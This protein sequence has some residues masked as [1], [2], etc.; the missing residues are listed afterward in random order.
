MFANAYRLLTVFLLGLLLPQPGWAESKLYIVLS[1]PGGAYE[2]VVEGFRQTFSGRPFLH[3]S[4]DETT[5]ARI[6]ELTSEPNLILPVGIRA[7]R[8]VA[9]HHA[10]QASVLELMVP[11]ATAEG[12]V[13][14]NRVPKNRISA[15]YI[16]QPTHRT[17]S[18]I[19]AGMP[20]VQRVGVVLSNESAER[21]KQLEAEAQR[22]DLQLKVRLVGRADEVGPVLRNMLEDVDALLLLP[23][24]ITFNAGNVQ[25]VLLAAYRQRVP[26]VGFS[27]GLVKAGAAA[28]VYATPVQVGRQGGFMAARWNPEAGDLP[29]AQAP[30]DYSVSVNRQV[31]RSL[32]LSVP[33]EREI[34]RRMKGD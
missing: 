33:D 19:K 6:R 29:P 15:V 7:S 11:K 20:G 12:I 22:F 24:P 9:E 18:L 34:Q 5:A 28:S 32:D 13:W 25:N 16:D 2:E 26:V 17:L 8:F 1:E 31:V 30:T 14:P 4:L 27:S 10:G 21:L 23:D 3:M